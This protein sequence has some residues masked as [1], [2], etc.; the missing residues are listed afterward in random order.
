MNTKDYS[1]SLQV[2]G[3]NTLKTSFAVSFVIPAFNEADT[4]SS[5]IEN[6]RD[7][8]AG[9][10]IIVVDDASTDDTKEISIKAGAD[11]VIR[12]NKNRGPGASF[13][14]GIIHSSGDFVI[15]VDADGQHPLGEIKKVFDYV[16][17]NPQIDAVF[18]ERTN[19]YSSGIIRSTGKI[20]INYVVQRLIEEK[21]TDHNCGLRAFRRIKILPFIFMLPDGFSYV[22]TSLVLAYKEDF[23]IHWIPI[24]MK[25]RET[26]KSHVKVRHGFNT[27]LLV[28]RLIVNFDPMKFFMPLT[29]ISFIIG[30]LSVIYNWVF[31]DGPGKNY[32]F[33]FLFGTLIFVLGILS[34]QMSVL[35]KEI[36]NLKSKE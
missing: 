5:V 3:E 24:A 33:F 23:C 27:I 12:H 1:C 32:I 20:L 31:Y 9:Q 11:K 19:V 14:T 6:L 28:F 13:K 8:F 18:T 22:T 29:W 4:I 15:I 30:I 35:R 34:E 21:I 17:K 16:I 36:L 10:E 25:Q 2:T 7:N 26:G